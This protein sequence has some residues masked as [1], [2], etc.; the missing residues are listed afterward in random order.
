MAEPMGPTSLV[1]ML[2]A[3]GVKVVEVPGWRTHNR[4]SKGAWGPVHGVTLHH[5]VTPRSVDGVGLCYRGYEGLPGPLC[6]GV[7]RR[8]GE[9]HLVGNGRANH[10]GGGDPN[11]LQAVKDERYLTYPP[12]PQ[13]GNSNG[14]DGNAHFYG[15]EC[16]NM[17]DG[18]EPWPAVQVEAMIR[19]SAAICRFYGWTAKSV[20]GHKEWSK[21]KND[22]RGPGD[23]VSMP[24]LRGKIQERLNHAPS[25]SPTPT[26]P[27]PTQ[28]T[29]KP[30]TPNGATMATPNLTVLSRAEDITLLQDQETVIYWTT[31]NYDPAST[32]GDGGKTVLI[33][34]QYNAVVS[35]TLGTTL[36]TGEA[37]E[38]YAVEEDAS[39]NRLGAGVAVTVH[40]QGSTGSWPVTA[41]VP[42]IGRVTQRLAFAVKN[43]QEA[44]VTISQAWLTMQSNPNV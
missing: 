43:R 11:V 1:Q 2:R 18:S 36:D 42:F 15:F 14:V 6:H 5:T 23:V 16:E 31:E 27:A 10:A 13:Y 40:G 12:T 7:I 21:D 41:S 8:N 3:E 29:P 37:V 24:R 9:V 19:A 28:P 34:G 25:W 26:A 30:T 22:P 32:H 33:N 44:P 39:G 35:L 4:N 17:G 20:I 38:V